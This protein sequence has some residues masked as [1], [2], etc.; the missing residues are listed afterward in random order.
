[1]LEVLRGEYVKLVRLKGLTGYVI[2]AVHAFKS[3]LI[4]VLTLAGVNLVV[5]RNTPAIIE[6]IFAWSGMPSPA[7]H[8]GAGQ[9]VHGASWRAGIYCAVCPRCVSAIG[10]QTLHAP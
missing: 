8:L 6:V 7:C 3:A 2:L 4:P 5:M 1:M 10:R 9:S